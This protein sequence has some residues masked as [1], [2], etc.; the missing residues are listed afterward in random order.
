[1]IF[2]IFVYVILSESVISAPPR[3]S[4]LQILGDLREESKVTIAATVTGGTEGSS[5]VQWFK[6]ISPL[7]QGENDLEAV[8]SSKIAKVKEAN[9]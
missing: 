8:S 5:R 9:L 1:M 7:F 3:V 4:G 6:K 2:S